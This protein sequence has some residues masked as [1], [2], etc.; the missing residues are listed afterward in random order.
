MKA[1]TLLVFL[2]FIFFLLASSSIGRVNLTDNGPT[3]AQAAAP[4]VAQS[5]AGQTAAQP[6]VI[7][8]QDNTTGQV[9]NIVPV[10]GQCT[11]PYIVQPGDTIS[12]IAEVCNTSVSAIRTANPGISNINLIYVGQQINIPG[13]G[14]AVQQQANPVPVTGGSNELVVPIQQPT[15]A[16][17]LIVP[18]APAFSGGLPVIRAGTSVQVKGLNYPPNTPVNIAVGP[19]NAGY[20]IISAA[21]TDASGSVVTNITLPTAPD[22]NTPYVVVVA[23]A[24]TPVIQAM[25]LPFY[26]GPK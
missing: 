2:F 3:S 21:I 20:T 12:L 8:I 23:T 11:N 16:P 25:S 7:T 4:A 9:S 13:A 26:I 5:S 24:S 15:A 6:Q 22:S 14:T 17:T 19:Q 10:T 18:A 1:F